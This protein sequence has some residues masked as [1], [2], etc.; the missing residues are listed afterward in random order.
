MSVSGPETQGP[1]FIS[2]PRPTLEFLND[3]GAF[4]TCTA[5]GL[6]EPTISWVMLDGTSVSQLPHIREITQNGS[7]YFPPF[8]AENYRHD[9]HSTS[10]QCLASNSVGQVLSREVTVQAVVKQHYDVT[11]RDTY[12]LTGNTAVL[13]CEIP[14][15]VKGHVSITSWVQDSSFNIYP[16]PYSDGKH[17]ML[18]SGELLVYSATPS[19]SQPTYRC[20]TVHHITGK[21]VESSTYGRVIVTGQSV[22]FLSSFNKNEAVKFV[23]RFR[24]MLIWVGGHKICRF[25]SIVSYH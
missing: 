4:L 6:P 22:N 25:V 12:V 11:V 15:F 20:R 19:D 16:A 8:G 3:M 9:V 21:T 14:T 13:K 23:L 5:H 24:L 1:V 17:H 10:Y 7:L 2:E 18:P